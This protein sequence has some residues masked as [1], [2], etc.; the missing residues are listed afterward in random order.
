VRG[1]RYLLERAALNLVSN[2]VEASPRGSEIRVVV[3]REAGRDG[4]LATFSVSDRGH[5]IAPERLDRLFDAFLSTKR[6]GAHLGMGLANVKRIVDAHGGR[7]TV[8]STVG[9]GS[10]FRIAL[11]VAPPPDQ[12]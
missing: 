9:E 3:G 12:A 11:P 7:V 8:T 1:D 5:G 4:E 10:T 6:T 2:A